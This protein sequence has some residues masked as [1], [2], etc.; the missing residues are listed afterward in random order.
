MEWACD[1]GNLRQ[2]DGCDDNCRVEE[3]FLC[4]G[5]TTLAPDVCHEECGDR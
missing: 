5:G 3:G 2:G 4:D 1:D